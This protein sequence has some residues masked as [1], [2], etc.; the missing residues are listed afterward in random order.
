MEAE[1]LKGGALSFD[2]E[3]TAADPEVAR[4]VTA[5]AVEV[6]RDGATERGSWF[7]NPGVPIPEEA[8]KIHGVTDAMA[9]DYS[10]P[11]DAMTSILGVLFAASSRH[12][13]LIVMNAPYDLTLVN[14]EAT[15][16][17][18]M[19]PFGGYCL[20]P[21]V[22][23]RGMDP[24]RKGKRTL[25]DL[26]AHYGVTQGEAH[27]AKGDALSAARIVWAQAKRYKKLEPYSLADMQLWQ[28]AS[29]E[30]W[31]KGFQEYLRKKNP[32]A[33]IDPTWPIR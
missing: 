33:V 23:D 31:A 18:L 6:G 22:I 26:A 21:L 27:N 24:W 13:P 14:R 9:A 12:I 17:G 29:H 2:T 8:T 11:V 5:H 25:T 32:D 1:W 7:V 16:V 4:I 19:F 3:T 20:D 28:R 30:N 15:R 10:K